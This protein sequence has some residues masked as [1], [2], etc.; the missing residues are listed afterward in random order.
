MI[1]F[2]WPAI[3]IVFKLQITCDYKKI[4]CRH[5]QHYRYF[6]YGISINGDGIRSVFII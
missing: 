2:Y 5:M 3:F 4:F 1:D 6:G